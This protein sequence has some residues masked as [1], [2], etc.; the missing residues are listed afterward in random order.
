MDLS[1]PVEVRKYLKNTW[2]EQMIHPERHGGARS[3]TKVA[4][5]H[6]YR[7]TGLGYDLMHAG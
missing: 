7:T 3:G 1:T 2:S 5:G 6:C 4:L